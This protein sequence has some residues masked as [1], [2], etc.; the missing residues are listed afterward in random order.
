MIW[1]SELYKDPKTVK[2]IV[3]MWETLM[4]QKMAIVCFNQRTH[5]IAGLNIN[6][7]ESKGER[8]M[9]EI[10]RQVRKQIIGQTPKAKIVK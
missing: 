8:I 6:F 10:L 2:G 9:D 1:F 3:L 5:E 7:V 4:K